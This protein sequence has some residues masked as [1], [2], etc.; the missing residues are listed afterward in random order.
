MQCRIQVTNFSER[1]NVMATNFPPP[2]KINVDKYQGKEK[3]N[4]LCRVASEGKPKGAAFRQITPV[5]PPR[6]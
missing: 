6:R 5:L 3:A 4:G 1:L 2:K